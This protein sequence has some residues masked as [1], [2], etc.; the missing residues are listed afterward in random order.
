[1]THQEKIDSI[2]DWFDF[3]KVAL[4]MQA[5]NWEWADAV[6]CVPSE[7][8]IREHGRR[9]LR[10]AIEKGMAATGGFRAVYKD[11]ILRLEFI[12]TD[13]EVSDERL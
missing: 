1:M 10:E 4:A 6:E 12:L 5:L 13:W 8:E 7:G 3:D 11:G 2:M 9:L